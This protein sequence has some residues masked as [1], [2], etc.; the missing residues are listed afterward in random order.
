MKVEFVGV[1]VR[2]VCTSVS[3]CFAFLSLSAID[4]AL[5]RQLATLSASSLIVGLIVLASLIAYLRV[6]ATRFAA[7]DRS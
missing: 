4:D 5:R 6:K 7:V 2:A 3:F 1:I